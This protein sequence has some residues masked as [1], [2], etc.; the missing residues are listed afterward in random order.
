M[1]PPSSTDRVGRRFDGPD[2]RRDPLRPVRAAGTRPAPTAWC[3][4]RSWATSISSTT[5]APTP[6]W[7]SASGERW[8]AGPRRCEVKLVEATPITGG[9][10]FEMRQRARAP[11]PQRPG[12]ASGRARPTAAATTGRSGGAKRPGGP[13]PP[14]G[15]LK[16]VQQGQA[17]VIPRLPLI[18]PRP[19]RDSQAL[20]RASDTHGTFLARVVLPKRMDRQLD[21][22]G[23]T[24][25]F[26]GMSGMEK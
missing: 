18:T 7:A 3:R 17:A 23:M 26:A 25:N 22:P 10:L 5:T 24:G 2:H 19:R 1:W 12:P 16:G 4:S 20:C 11:R 9:L 13:K 14:S 6:W 8:R 15:G 21:R